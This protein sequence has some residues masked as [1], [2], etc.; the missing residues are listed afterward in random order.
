METDQ[1]GVDDVLAALADPARR[2]IVDLLGSRA[3]RPGELSELL[4]VSAPIISRHLR[5][6]LQAGLVEDE[7]VPDD[8]RVRLFRLRTQGIAP[9]SAWLGQLQTSWDEQLAGFKAYAEVRVPAAR[10]EKGAGR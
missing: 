5:T 2:R 6:L 3:Y 10:L 1:N 4:G 9:L 7:R 8:A